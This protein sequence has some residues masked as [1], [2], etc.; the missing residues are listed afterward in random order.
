MEPQER[1]EHHTAA[2]AR[3]VVGQHTWQ[4][5][6]RGA[7]MENQNQPPVRF[8][9]GGRALQME[10]TIVVAASARLVRNVVG[11]YLGG[12]LGGE[13][14]FGGDVACEAVEGELDVVY[15]VGFAD[16]GK[17]VGAC[18]EAEE[19]VQHCPSQ[20]PAFQKSGYTFYFHL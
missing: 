18:W 19:S 3:A 20:N 2:F 12:V 9:D 15:E 13:D 17:G 14:G 6:G 1:Q 5:I 10:V 4:T 16:D 11:G 7:W 8:E